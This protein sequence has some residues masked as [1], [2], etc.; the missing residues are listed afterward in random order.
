MSSDGREEDFALSCCFV[1]IYNET[2]RDL[3]GCR[4]DICE[5]R[6]DPERGVVLQHA[7]TRRLTSAQQALTLLL[8]GNKRRTQEATD[9]NQTSSRS[10]AILQVISHRH[11]RKV[12]TKRRKLMPSLFCLPLSCHLL[13]LYLP[14]HPFSC[15][16]LCLLSVSGHVSLSLRVF[17][18]SSVCFL[19]RRFLC[20]PPSFSL[21]LYPSL[22]FFLRI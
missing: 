13:Y 10:H 6:E 16:S 7:A 20:L 18:C 15:V 5:L 12:T 21:P 1:E 3:L 8:E 19:L 22:I 17:F 14:L 4:T 9:A 2:I 11:A